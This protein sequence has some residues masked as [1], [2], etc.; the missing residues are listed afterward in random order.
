MLYTSAEAA[1]LL[2]EKKEAYEAVIAKENLASTFDAS[3]GEAVEDAGA[4][5]KIKIKLLEEYYDSSIYYSRNYTPSDASGVRF[6]NDPEHE[7]EMADRLLAMCHWKEKLEVTDSADRWIR[8][9]DEKDMMV[10]LRPEQELLPAEREKIEKYQAEMDEHHRELDR[11]LGR[12]TEEP[13]V[14]TDNAV[15]KAVRVAMLVRSPVCIGKEG[16]EPGEG[17]PAEKIRN[18]SVENLV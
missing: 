6:Q 2:K 11:M 1:K 3:I 5:W 9:E 17:Y 13:V 10:D 15:Y 12:E 4:K 18:T 16:T 8:P 14:V 7:S